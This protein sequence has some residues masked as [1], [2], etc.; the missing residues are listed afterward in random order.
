[1]QHIF[2]DFMKINAI[3]TKIYKPEILTCPKCKKNLKYAYTIS[4][5]TIQFT[6]GKKIKIKNMGYLCPYCNDNII[7]PSLTASKLAYKG[8]TYSCKTLCY[9]DYWKNKGLSREIIADEFEKM[10]VIVTSR[11]IDFLYEKF[12]SYYDND[13]KSSF[14][15]AFKEMINNFNE[16]RLSIDLI[17]IKEK[18]YILFY[19]GFNGNIINKYVSESFEEE[20]LLNLLKEVLNNKKLRYVIS[21]RGNVSP[22]ISVMKGISKSNIKYISYTKF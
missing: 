4:F 9:I 12:K 19:N 16:I 7:Y 13:L 2:G 1:M 10:G 3:H 18:Y 5:K 14:D 21:V 22:F 15:N 6:S 17:T 11:N 20:G 8:L